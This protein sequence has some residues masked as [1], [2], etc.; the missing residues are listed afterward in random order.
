[1]PE[2]RYKRENHSYLFVPRKNTGWYKVHNAEG[3]H[4]DGRRPQ[5]QL[6]SSQ[7]NL[8]ALCD[9]A[10]AN[11]TSA[12]FWILP[13]KGGLQGLPWL[14]YSLAE[15]FPPMTIFNTEQKENRENRWWR[16]NSVVD[17]TVTGRARTAERSFSCQ[18]SSLSFRPAMT[19]SH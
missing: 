4:S 17:G 3:M 8:C 9:T 6:M 13:R 2:I 7:C 12:L 1:M 5:C 15:H 10:S 18:V 11:R 19:A 16:A 14:G